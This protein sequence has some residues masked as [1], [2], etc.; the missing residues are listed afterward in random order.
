M[1]PTVLGRQTFVID[2]QP[3]SGYFHDAVR[4][5]LAHAIDNYDIALQ[6]FRE[7][8]D[9]RRVDGMRPHLLKL[10]VTT[11]NGLRSAHILGQPHPAKTHFSV[12]AHGD[13]PKQQAINGADQPPPLE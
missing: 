11:G 4:D 1:L 7:G 13:Y 2:I 12:P 9:L 5:E 3:E 6:A 8:F 10:I